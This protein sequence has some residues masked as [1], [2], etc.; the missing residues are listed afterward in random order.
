MVPN[1]LATLSQ[2]ERRFI[3][4]VQGFQQPEEGPTKT[5]F[6]RSSSVAELG[7][8]GVEDFPVRCKA[9]A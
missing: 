8:R 7:H 4:A 5:E 2:A 1:R 9:A 6:N 3:P